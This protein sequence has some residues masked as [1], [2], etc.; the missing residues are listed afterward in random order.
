LLEAFQSYPAGAEVTG[1]RPNEQDQALIGVLDRLRWEQLRLPLRLRALRRKARMQGG[2]A[3]ALLYSPALGAPLVSPIP[4]VAHV[5]DLIPLREPAQFSGLASWYWRRLLPLS[6]KR[7]RLITVSNASLVDEVETLLRYG[8]GRI[9]VVPYYPDPRTAVLAA[10]IQPDY[11]RPSLGA[12][13]GE[14]LFLCLASH[15]S[16]KNIELPIRALAALK[17]RGMQARLVCVGGLTAHTQALAELAARTGV[18]D[19]VEFP[20]YLEQRKTVRLL[21]G[22][23][24]LLFMSRLEGFGMPP[25]EAQ[26][27]GCAVVLSDIPCHRAVYADPLRWAQLDPGDRHPPVLLDPDD[28]AGLASEMA[29]LISDPQYR[30]GLRRAGLAYSAA[31]TAEATAAALHTAFEAALS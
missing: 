1:L 3:P 30:L 7:C 15:E 27:I 10:E 20:G 12:A 22:A 11:Q 14:P 25:Q 5:H 16:R 19:C 18:A 8:R 9:H 28:V 21:L 29:R 6:W 23:T 24:A 17:N 13:S 26:S 4:V 31:F 2:E